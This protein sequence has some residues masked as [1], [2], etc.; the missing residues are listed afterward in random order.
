MRSAVRFAKPRGFTLVELMV[1]VAIVGLL[2]SMA[3]PSFQ[4]YSW[5]ARRAERD[6]ILTA[7]YMGVQDVT[8]SQQ[9]VPGGAFAGAWNPPGVPGPAKRRWVWGA[10][11]W[12]QLPVIVQGDSYY[13]YSF[14]A[15]DPSALGGAGDMT[16]D[17]MSV[18]D[19]DADLA[20]D[21]KSRHYIGRGF[22]FILDS[23]AATADGIF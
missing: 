1:V 15:V 2:S 9:R 6:T 12:T 5:R 20:Q 3:I 17:V 16:L 18:G 21:F 4:R 10:G 7:L 19:L 8:Q 13:S 23:E 22:S 11:G 14:V